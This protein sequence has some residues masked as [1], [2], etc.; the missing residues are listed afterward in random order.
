MP[1]IKYITSTELVEIG[2]YDFLGQTRADDDGDYEMEYKLQDGS[3]VR[4]KSNL[5]DW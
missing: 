1:D 4:V 5:F 3:I 2:N